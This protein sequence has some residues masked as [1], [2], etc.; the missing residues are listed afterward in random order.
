MKNTRK[1]GKKLE[2]YVCGSLSKT[3]KKCKLTNNSGAVSNNGDIV[4][5][6]FVIECK[7]RNV[8]NV[9]IDRKVW[10]KLCSQI[11]LDTLKIPL[12]ILENAHNEKWAVLDL[13]DFLR[14]IEEKDNGTS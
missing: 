3:D 11:R 12:L 2:N 7:K 13:K 6:N 1:T 10:F 14:L 9:K 4:H 8:E 5:K